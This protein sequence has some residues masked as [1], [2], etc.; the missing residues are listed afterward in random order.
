MARADD[1]LAPNCAFAEVDNAGADLS[2]KVEKS[3]GAHC[4]QGRHTQTENEDRKQ[5]NAA[6][7]SRHS[8]ESPDSKPHQALDQQI[9]VRRSS[10]P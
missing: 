7:D 8:D 3:V 1:Y 9:H 6:S 2:D 5:Q 10:R 4:Q